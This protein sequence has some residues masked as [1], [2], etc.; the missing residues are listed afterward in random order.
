MSSELAQHTQLDRARTSLCIS[1]LASK[2]LI[3]RQAVA[4]DG[5][6]AAVCL[7]DKGCEV[8]AAFFPVVVQ[9]NAQLMQ[10]LSAEQ[11]AHLDMALRTLQAQ[12]DQA[13]SDTSLPKANRRQG[14]R[15]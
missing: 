3:S 1:S 2:G 11:I 13:P 5:R 8:Y 15:R 9:I 6:K 7:T 10:V 14:R 4:G 12:A